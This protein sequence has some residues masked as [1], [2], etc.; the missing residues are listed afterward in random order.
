V[1]NDHKPITAG[2]DGQNTELRVNNI[3][4]TGRNSVLVLNDFV[5]II[6]ISLGNDLI[7]NNGGSSETNNCAYLDT[8]AF[9]VNRTLPVTWSSQTQVVMNQGASEISFSTAQQINNSHFEIEHSQKIEA[10][11]QP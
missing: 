9:A 3:L 5:T 4:V 10:S 7:Q 11:N 2:E 1:E 6:G 8:M